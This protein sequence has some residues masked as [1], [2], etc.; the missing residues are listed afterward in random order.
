MSEPLRCRGVVLGYLY[1]IVAN[2]VTFFDAR[3]R[4]SSSRHFLLIPDSVPA[5]DALGYA[6]SVRL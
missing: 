4:A 2:L 1:K 5:S 3:A 6:F